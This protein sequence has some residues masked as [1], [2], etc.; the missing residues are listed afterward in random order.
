MLHL[1]TLFWINFDNFA[2]VSFVLPFR[3]STRVPYE[4]FIRD[5][6]L[7]NRRAMLLPNL[8]TVG[9]MV[10]ET[11]V[12]G[13]CTQRLGKHGI[14]MRK[15]K[16]NER[17][18]TKKKP[19]Q[20]VEWERRCGRGRAKR[21][22]NPQKRSND[23]SP[24]FMLRLYRFHR[25]SDEASHVAWPRCCVGHAEVRLTRET[26]W[27]T[28]FFSVSRGN[29]ALPCRGELVIIYKHRLAKPHAEPHEIYFWRRRG[30]NFL[31]EKREIER[32]CARGGC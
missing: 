26:F 8:H 3:Y 16:D 24:G 11:R 23:I 19:G 5:A 2:R 1:V 29:A 25:R 31:G 28:W 21:F 10:L 9:Y 14:S 4:P 15:W 20:A 27:C 6:T 7:A 32:A 18:K 30:G 12:L 13:E 22:Y 17:V